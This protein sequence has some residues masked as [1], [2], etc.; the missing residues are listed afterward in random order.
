MYGYVR[1]CTDMYGYVQICMEMYGDVRICTE[2]LLYPGTNII[3]PDKQITG[4][5]MYGY[6]QVCTDMYGVEI[7]KRVKPRRGAGKHRLWL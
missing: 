5:D 2:S 1:I 7:R 6:V 4:T 3:R